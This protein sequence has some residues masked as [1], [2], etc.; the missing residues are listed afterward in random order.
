MNYL[1]YGGIVY[2]IP[3]YEKVGV[4]QIARDEGNHLKTNS[5]IKTHKRT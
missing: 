2:I 1:Y 5:F 3:R 4:V